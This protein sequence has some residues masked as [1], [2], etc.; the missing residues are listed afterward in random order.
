MNIRV[1]NVHIKA[2][3][4]EFLD[5]HESIRIL[6]FW[7]FLSTDVLLFGSLFSVY[8]VYRS[9]VALGPT[10]AQIFT[11]G[12][13]LAETLILLTSSF[14]CSLSLY[15]AR[16]NRLKGAVG[17]L[18]VTLLLGASFVTLE[19]QEFAGDVLHGHT[20][21]QSAFL[22]G[23]FT[24]VG[25]HGSHVTFGIGWAIMLALQLAMKGLTATNRRK[26]YTFALYWH[27]LDIV[28]IFLFSVVYLAGVAH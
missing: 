23:F 18:V 10:P 22:S 5:N 4:Q 25:T 26:L 16:I 17:W 24:L 7:V 15:M 27:F 28:W 13:V 6:G 1:E 19:I 20:W 12:P 11:L 21:H 8:A 14:T 9:R 2:R 3:P